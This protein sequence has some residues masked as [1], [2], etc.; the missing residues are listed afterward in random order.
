MVWARAHAVLFS[1]SFHSLFLCPLRVI[2]CACLRVVNVRAAAEGFSSRITSTLCESHLG[3]HATLKNNHVLFYNTKRPQKMHL[4]T[5]VNACMHACMYTPE[6]DFCEHTWISCRIDMQA[7]HRLTRAALG[8]SSPRSQLVLLAGIR[9]AQ[10]LILKPLPPI[11]PITLWP[12]VRSWKIVPSRGRG[13][14]GIG[15]D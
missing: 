2:V 3:L 14:G 8:I 10:C 4:F 5:Q 13:G 7:N 12:L 11:V 15:R 1:W 9:V 6:I